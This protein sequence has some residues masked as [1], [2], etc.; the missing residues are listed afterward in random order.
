MKVKNNRLYPYPVLSMYH[1][2]YKDNTFNAEDIELS[3]DSETATVEGEIIINDETIKDLIANGF[4]RLYCHIECSTTKFRKIYEVDDN[5][6][7]HCK[8]DVPL[9]DICDTVEI[10]FVLVANKTIENYSND[11]LSDFYNGA[12]ITLY[13]YSTLGYT[14]TI[15]YKIKKSLNS[16]G[17]IPSVFDIIKS[18]TAEEISFEYLNS[19]KIQVFLP[20]YDYGVYIDTKGD[21]I[22]TKQMMTV[23]PALQEI[24]E[25]INSSAD[26][27]EF[28]DR[29]WFSILE[30]AVSKLEGYSDGFA[31][32]NFK[33]RQLSMFALAQKA[34]KAVSS[35][36]FKEI[37]EFVTREDA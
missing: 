8:I 17:D 10:C 35:D 15:E 2:D 26:T 19:D 16:N 5:D 30:K 13:E 27:S 6:L 36:A 7:P 31:S 20:A 11:N 14:D 24:F 32:D 21:A 3:Y 22:R 34:L 37:D 18:E 23:V 33:N 29:A 4:I 28:E 1:D 9:K 25:T 12:R